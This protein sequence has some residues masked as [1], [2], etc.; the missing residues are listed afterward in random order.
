MLSFLSEVFMKVIMLT[1]G[2]DPC[3]QSSSQ[4]VSSFAQAMVESGFEV[5]VITASRCLTRTRSNSPS[6]IFRVY[7]LKCPRFIIPLSNLIINPI[8]VLLFCFMAIPLLLKRKVDVLLASVPYGEVA[9]AGFFLSK[10]F[11]FPLVVDMRDMYPPPSELS[12]VYQRLPRRVNEI[13]TSLFLMVYKTSGKIICVDSYIKGRLKALGIAEEKLFVVPNGADV[14]IHKPCKPNRREQIR[15]EYGL[16]LDSVIFVYAGSLTCYYPVIEAI[17]G[18]GTR[19]PEKDKF[20]LLIISYSGYAFYRGFTSNVGLKDKVKFIGPL[21]VSQTA[22]VLSACDVGIVAYGSEDYWKGAY[23]S[24]IFSYMSCGLPVLASG[25]SGSVIDLLINEHQVGFFVGSPSAKSFA[26]GFSFFLK[27][28]NMLDDMG[29]NAVKVVR[30]LYD[31]R[32][33]GR[34]LVALLKAS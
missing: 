7:N 27:N 18:V 3:P 16:P 12:M 10:V 32:V 25:P 6:K 33:L 24:K 23:G 26:R 30:R 1:Y 8:L 5:T 4:R 9:I 14:F 19:L 28:K 2:F 20:Q 15:L 13:L 29:K 31:R 22:R 34:E 17:K 11:R 21:S